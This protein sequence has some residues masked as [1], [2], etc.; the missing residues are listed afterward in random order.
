MRQPCG[1]DLVA[2]DVTRRSVMAA[3]VRHGEAHHLA[4]S[5]EEVVVGVNQ[6]DPHLV[7]TGRQSVYVDGI[8]IARIRP[9]PRQVVHGYV[10]MTHAWGRVKRTLSKYGSYTNI[11]RSVLDPDKALG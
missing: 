4:L 8:A 11:L 10:Q 9:Q 7:R 1:P 6:V 2:D 5:G 3:P